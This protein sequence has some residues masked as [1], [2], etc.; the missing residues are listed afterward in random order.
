M[1]NVSIWITSVT[2]SRFVDLASLEP[3]VANA[4]IVDLHN[5]PLLA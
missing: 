3:P 2:L 4:S 1:P 5:V